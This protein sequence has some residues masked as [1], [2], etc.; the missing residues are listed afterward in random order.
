MSKKWWEISG[1][2]ASAYD[3][4]RT[5]NMLKDEEF[6]FVREVSK[7]VPQYA[8]H[9]ACKALKNFFRG[10][11]GFPKFKK[12]GR[13][14]DT[15]H[16]SADQGFKIED[17]KFWVLKL[18]WVKMVEAIRF[19]GKVLNATISRYADHWYVTF[20][21]QV[22]DSYQYPHPCKTQAVVG[23]DF[24]ISTLMT[25]SNGSQNDVPVKIEN[26][27]NLLRREKK[28]KRL[29]R[30]LSRKSRGSNRYEKAR[31]QL[32]RQHKKV[33]DCRLHRIHDLT[34]KLVKRFRFITIEDLNVR[35]MKRNRKLAKHIGD[36]SF[37]E[38]RRQ[39]EYKSRLSGSTV[40]VADR[41]FPS[42]KLCSGCGEKNEGLTLSDRTWTCLSCGAEHDRDVNAAR[43]LRLVALKFWETLNA[44]GEDVR[45]I[46]VRHRQTSKKCELINRKV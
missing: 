36:A 9:D 15:F 11:H 4:I 13:S 46:V 3:L 17:H 5:F 14:K 32:A 35:G 6:P 24:G 29:D 43:N 26:P 39:L 37:Y 2:T 23:V 10:T 31:T 42:S 33:T 30:Q 12:K 44:H 19:P 22:D 34:T 7:C 38:I 8:T 28:L 41:F 40:V 21:I 27:R 20:Q 1:K 18:G 16:L 25:L 45:P